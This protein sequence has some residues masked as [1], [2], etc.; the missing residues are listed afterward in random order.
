[1]SKDKQKQGVSPGQEI[2]LRLGVTRGP[3]FP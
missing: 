2:P 1:M 3:N